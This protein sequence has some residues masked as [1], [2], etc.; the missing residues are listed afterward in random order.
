MNLKPGFTTI[1]HSFNPACTIVESVV[2]SNGVIARS[3]ATRQ[4]HPS[5][6]RAQPAVGFFCH[7]ELRY[8][9]CDESHQLWENRYT[10]DYKRWIG[11]YFLLFTP[12]PYPYCYQ[13]SYC[14]GKYL[15]CHVRENLLVP[16]ERIVYGK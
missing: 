8:V 7:P 4:S 16:V 13:I 12:D 3:K 2:Y 5:S 11:P 10:P 1:I 14:L 6:S 9:E 15:P